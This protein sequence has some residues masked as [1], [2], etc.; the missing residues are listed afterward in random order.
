MVLETKNYEIAY[1]IS[2]ALTEEEALNYANECNSA[3]EEAKGM[4]RHAEAPKIHQLAYPVK[5]EINAYFGWTTFSL[6]PE[7]V[8]K[9]EK[10]VKSMEKI[11]RHVIV[12][13][14]TEKPKGIPYMMRGGA[15]RPVSQ[16][17]DAS[18]DQQEEPKLDL[19]ALDKKLDEILGK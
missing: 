16:A 18:A 17:P 8:L 11:L 14:D 13:E 10:K 6:S 12:I 7:H 9:L 2:P 1:L 15:R 3:I 5:K 19:E 4:I